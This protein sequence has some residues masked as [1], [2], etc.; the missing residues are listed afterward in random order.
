[1]KEV[2]TTL[3]LPARAM[4]AARRSTVTR[5]VRAAEVDPT[6]KVVLNT[7]VAA[8]PLRRGRIVPIRSAERYVVEYGDPARAL[9]RREFIEFGCGACQHHQRRPDL[10]AYHCDLGMG[11][12]PDGTNK[13]CRRFMRRKKHYAESKSPRNR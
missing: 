5:R 9:E 13:T 4:N 2:N 11:L 1:M 7:A 3:H 8:I 12:W 6:S 10:S